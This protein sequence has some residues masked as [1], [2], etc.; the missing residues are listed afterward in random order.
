LV[1]QFFKNAGRCPQTAKCLITK[2]GSCDKFSVKTKN[3]I[4]QNKRAFCQNQAN[5]RKPSFKFKQRKKAK[6][7]WQSKRGSKAT[8]FCGRLISCL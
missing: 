2:K 6:F 7:C 1:Q 3:K 4:S 5:D 8:N